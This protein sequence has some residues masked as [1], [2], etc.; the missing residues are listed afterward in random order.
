MEIYEE[1]L[2]YFVKLER[3]FMQQYKDNIQQGFYVFQQ[4]GRFVSSYEP[5][6]RELLNQLNNKILELAE[7]YRGKGIKEIEPLLQQLQQRQQQQ[8]PRE[9]NLNPLEKFQIPGTK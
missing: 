3:K 9:P 2:R 4:I 5:G 6:N 1:N 7:L 8:Q